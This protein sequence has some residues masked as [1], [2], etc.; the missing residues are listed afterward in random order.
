MSDGMKRL[1]P[2]C[3]KVG[4]VPANENDGPHP[5]Y[6]RQCIKEYNADRYRKGS[7]LKDF[8]PEFQKRILEL[9][10]PL[11]ALQMKYGDDETV[12]GLIMKVTAL[13]GFLNSVER[14]IP[15]M[16]RDRRE[17]FEARK[18][19]MEAEEEES[20]VE[21]DSHYE[22]LMRQWYGLIAARKNVKAGE[23]AD[24]H[25]LPR[26]PDAFDRGWMPPSTD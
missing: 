14:K 9:N 8:F 22:L 16:V 21:R 15:G 4:R 5:S 11:M 26:Y 2:R 3:P 19:I 10:V 1:C 6:C 25:I 24:E 23:F 18:A 7:A 12:R 20:V 13:D 17:K